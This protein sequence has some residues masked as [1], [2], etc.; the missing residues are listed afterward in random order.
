MER[1]NEEVMRKIKSRLDEGAKKYGEEILI[2]DDREF[3]NEALE[4][5]LDACVYLSCKMIQLENKFK[6][7]QN[8][9]EC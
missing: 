7:I 9:P 8:D 2:D 4:E 6:G 1:I 3:V 5:L